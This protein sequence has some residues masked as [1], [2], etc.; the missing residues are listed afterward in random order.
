MIEFEGIILD[1]KITFIK[2]SRH[3]DNG[4]IKSVE[5]PIDKIIA[6]RI[7]LYLGSILPPA[8]KFVER[9]NEEANE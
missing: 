3:E 2:L 8:P 7:M 1:N 6:D 4:T 9:G 5:I